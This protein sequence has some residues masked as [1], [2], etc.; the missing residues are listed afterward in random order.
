MISEKRII[1]TED[2]VLEANAPWW[3]C[4]KRQKSKTLG[5]ME[6]QFGNK[7]IE[8]LWDSDVSRV[9]AHAKRWASGRGFGEA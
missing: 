7:S 6:G 5:S 3:D 4:C 2:M 1:G 9:Y 8:Y